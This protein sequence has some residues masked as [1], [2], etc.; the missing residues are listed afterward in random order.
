MR[1]GLR[2]GPRLHQPPFGVVE[3]LLVRLVVVLGR[4]VRGGVRG[5]VCGR[6]QLLG[7][8]ELPLPVLLRFLWCH[9]VG[10]EG[11]E[12][13]LNFDVESARTNLQVRICC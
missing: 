2:T 4:A 8:L 13:L 7:H 12:K 6:G 9:G 1:A 3:Q 11:N 10:L 5:G